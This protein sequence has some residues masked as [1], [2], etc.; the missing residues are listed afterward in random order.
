MRRR[1]RRCPC[2]CVAWRSVGLL[3]IAG[4]LAAMSWYVTEGPRARHLPKWVSN[5]LII[6]RI[7]SYWQGIVVGGIL[8]L[9]VAFDSYQTRLRQT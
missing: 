8:V 1:L 3:L 7:S 9:A 5:I 6:A 4:A 2:F